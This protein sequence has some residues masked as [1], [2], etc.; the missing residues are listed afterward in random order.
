MQQRLLDNFSSI[1]QNNDG[2]LGSMRSSRINS[3]IALDYENMNTQAK[4]PQNPYSKF[5]NSE[6]L[7]TAC[8]IKRILYTPVKKQKLF[9][10]DSKQTIL[11]SNPFCKYNKS[12]NPFLNPTCHKYENEENNKE[13]SNLKSN[14]FSSKSPVSNYEGSCSNT[15]SG[16]KIPVKKLDFSN[17]L[18]DC[19]YESVI[20]NLQS[21]FNA[22]SSNLFSKTKLEHK[23]FSHPLISSSE[24]SSQNSS[25]ISKNDNDSSKESEIILE[26][27]KETKVMLS[28]QQSNATATESLLEGL[29]KKINFNI[30]KE[31]TNDEKYKILALKKI[32]KSTHKDN[33]SASKMDDALKNK[34]QN[35]NDNYPESLMQCNLHNKRRK[36]VHS[37]KK[38]YASEIT[39]IDP[40]SFE[41][42]RFK[43]FKDS[44]IGINQ[45]W[46][47]YLKE[48]KADE[49]VPT[50]DELLENAT[51][52]VH[53]NLLESISFLYNNR[54]SSAVNN[55]CYMNKL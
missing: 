10:N 24:S 47:K 28:S 55:I 41:E 16:F 23:Q 15:S 46:Q 11:N 17:R 53:N 29:T 50:D 34:D 20:L 51:K 26:N 39:L 21:T 43:I 12:S 13:N 14:L 48:S 1:T 9:E 45:D 19:K 52:F 4:N 31:K 2:Y 37:V 27:F 7:E 3:K 6:Y 38:I 54:D 25:S 36:I 5:K 18:K 35:L 32:R 8:T 33:K 44:D 22:D 42:K 30:P 49:D 40:T